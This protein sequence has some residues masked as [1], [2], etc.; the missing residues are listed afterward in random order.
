MGIM[1]VIMNCGG[2]RA[3]LLRGMMSWHLIVNLGGFIFIC[4]WFWLVEI[5]Y[6]QA[7]SGD[8]SNFSLC[9]GCIFYVF[10]I[11]HNFL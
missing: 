4:N 6:L 7:S 3:K 1:K 11:A 10:E 5:N 9:G 8:K 2:Y